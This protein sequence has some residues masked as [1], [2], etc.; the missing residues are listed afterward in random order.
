VRTFIAIDLSPEIKDNLVT[1]VNHLK[2]LGRNVKW[3]TKENYHLTL[4]F[5]GEISESEAEQIKSTLADI[6]SRHHSFNLILKGMGSFPAGSNRIRI[7]WAGI[8]EEDELLS[9]GKEIETG[10][11]KKGF[12]KEDRPFS[13]H[14]TIGRV[15]TPEKQEKLAS[16]LARNNQLELGSML[17]REITFFQSILHPQGPEYR[18]ISRHL[19]S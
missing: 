7:V 4:K 14:L 9:L 13:P 5:L 11:E 12:P 15:K 19:L 17:V 10:L 2:P 16:E 1:L 18:V 8:A 3:V 6:A